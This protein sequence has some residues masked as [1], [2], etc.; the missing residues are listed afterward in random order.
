[1]TIGFVALMISYVYYQAIKNI[2]CCDKLFDIFRREI[3]VIS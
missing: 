3:K 2:S 1:M